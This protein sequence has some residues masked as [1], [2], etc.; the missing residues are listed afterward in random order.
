MQLCWRACQP[1]IRDQEEELVVCLQGCAVRVGQY[2]P[3]MG[4]LLR[5]KGSSYEWH[6]LCN[7]CSLCG[8]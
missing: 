8:N 4:L 6:S 7:S 1:W 5:F 3:C 2:V